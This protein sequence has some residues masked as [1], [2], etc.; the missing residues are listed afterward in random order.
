ME[1][2]DELYHHGVQGMHWGVRRYQP[3]PSDYHGDGKYVRKLT[4][5][6]R[7][8]SDKKKARIMAR[9]N[10]M[11][12]RSNKWTNRK[13]EKLEKKGKTAKADV[14]RELVK[15][16]EAS[17]ARKLEAVSNFTKGDLSTARAQGFINTILK[18]RF[19]MSEANVSSMATFIDRLGEYDYQRGLRWLSNFSSEGNFRNMTAKEGYKYLQKK[20]RTGIISVRP[21]IRVTTLA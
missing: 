8:I 21:N 7:P 18:E 14:M 15:D 16:N 5:K 20:N 10:T 12:D 9:I 19:A 6:S 4:R 3:Y 1:I 13:I 11:Y 2:F 17:R